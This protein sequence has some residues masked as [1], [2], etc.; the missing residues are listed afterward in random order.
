MK[1]PNTFT[2]AF[3]GLLL[4]TAIITAKRDQIASLEKT[5]RKSKSIRTLCHPIASFKDILS[6]SFENTP[7]IL[8]DNIIKI[9]LIISDFKFFSKV[10]C[11]Q[12]LKI[13]FKTLPP[14][15]LPEFKYWWS[16]LHLFL[17]PS[18]SNNQPFNYLGEISV[19]LLITASIPLLVY[20]QGNTHGLQNCRTGCN[21][22]VF[23]CGRIIVKIN[24]IL[25]LSWNFNF[26]WK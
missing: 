14:V 19:R 2:L 6:S 22:F 20:L 17:D 16:Q 11:R 24:R 3:N 9:V 4:K 18:P 13:S 26:I 12:L 23:W 25:T 7:S 5:L 15:M 10:P 1:N 8:P 21:G